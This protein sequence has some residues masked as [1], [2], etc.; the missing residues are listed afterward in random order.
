MT[1]SGCRPEEI[2][3]CSGGHKPRTNWLPASGGEGTWGLHGLVSAGR[4][5]LSQSRRLRKPSGSCFF[6]RDSRKEVP[7]SAYLLSGTQLKRTLQTLL[8]GPKR[9]GTPEASAS[10]QTQR[11]S[12][13]PFSLSVSTSCWYSLSLFTP[14][15]LSYSRTSAPYPSQSWME[16]IFLSLPVLLLLGAPRRPPFL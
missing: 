10:C 12:H 5:D 6:E 8:V 9:I 2:T 16:A 13:L 15:P 11:V 1:R 4:K 14:H 3:L 7:S